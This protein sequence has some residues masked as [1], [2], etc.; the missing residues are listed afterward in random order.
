MLVKNVLKGSSFVLFSLGGNKKP[1]SL[2]CRMP[3][4]T[5]EV[6][7]L[8]QHDLTLTSIVKFETDSLDTY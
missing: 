8:Q 4:I 3:T 1:N 5:T 2:T 7:K 6:S